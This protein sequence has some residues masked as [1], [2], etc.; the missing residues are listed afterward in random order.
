MH[1]YVSTC[2]S[3]TSAAVFVCVHSSVYI[4]AY[5]TV[6]L[7]SF[8]CTYY[9]HVC[10]AGSKYVC[11]HV[12]L[13][14]AAGFRS[15]CRCWEKT[16]RE[17]IEKERDSHGGKDKSKQV[18]FSEADDCV[19]VRVNLFI[20]DAKEISIEM[21]LV[22]HWPWIS[23]MADTQNVDVYRTQGREQKGMVAWERARGREGEETMQHGEII[24]EVRLG[25]IKKARGRKLEEML[26]RD[27]ICKKTEK[28]SKTLEEELHCRN[29]WI[30]SHAW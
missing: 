11:V 30:V 23:P 19:F 12:C 9:L 8:V 4:C 27:K 2:L 29:S 21:I 3:C 14:N 20:T 28:E 6:L 17:K 5:A 18:Q 1:D 25:G 13:L 15:E 24:R 22:T 16:E 10:C 7:Y 26:K